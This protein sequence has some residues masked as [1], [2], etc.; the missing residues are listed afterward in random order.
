MIMVMWVVMIMVMPMV[1]S[2]WE[3]TTHRI[4]GYQ[5]KPQKPQG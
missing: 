2:W 1:F 5:K 4:S 3:T